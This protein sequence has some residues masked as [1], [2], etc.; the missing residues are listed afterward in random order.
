VAHFAG[1]HKRDPRS[2]TVPGFA[3]GP[4]GEAWLATRGGLARH[5]ADGRVK[6]FT[7]KEGLPA[8][9]VLDVAADGKGRIWFLTAK[10][11]GRIEDDRL[12]MAESE[13]GDRGF[14]WKK[15]RRIAADAE[16]RV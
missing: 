8:D 16:G 7:A 10:G 9:D 6:I 13:G 3:A 4:N 2:A 5:S 12:A 11:L 15:A 1:S 14:N